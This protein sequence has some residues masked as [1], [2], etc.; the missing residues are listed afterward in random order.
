MLEARRLTKYYAGIPAVQDVNFRVQRGE[1][2]GLLGP[3]GSGKSTTVSIVSSLIEPTDGVV[4]MDGVSIQDRL[5]SFRGQLGYVPEEAHL[6]TYLTAPEFLELAGSLRDL[7]RVV[8]KR[9]I[10]AFLQVFGLEAEQHEPMYTFSKGMRQKVLMSAALL[11]NPDVL[12]L[13]EP[14]SGLDVTGTVVLRRLVRALAQAGKVVIYSSH[15]METIEQ[16]ATHV[17]I[18][19]ESRMVAY[20]TVANLRTLLNA[21]SLEA[22][23]RALVVEANVDSMVTDILR[24]ATL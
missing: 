22:V 17:L 12:V 15:E 14:A 3:N 5:L 24:A 20:D 18:L 7:D 2:L 23:F 16:V 1:I 13:D 10:A 6:Y 9:R 19:H 8:L 4:L 21:P 11:H